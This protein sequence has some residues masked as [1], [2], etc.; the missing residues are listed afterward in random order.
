MRDYSDKTIER[1]RERAM[2]AR[3][4]NIYEA[5]SGMEDYVYGRDGAGRYRIRG[6]SIIVKGCWFIDNQSGEKG[7]AVDFMRY[8]YGYDFKQAVDYLTDED[9]FRDYDNLPKFEKKVEEEYSVSNLDLNL[10]EK[11][12]QDF[13]FPEEDMVK[14]KNNI[15]YYL[16]NE[17][18]IDE[19]ILQ[20]LISKR[21]VRQDKHNNTVFVWYDHKSRI[22]GA[23]K[24]GTYE[25]N[26]NG[27]KMRFR[28]I[29]PNSV[30]G[31]GFNIIKGTPKKVIFFEASIDLISY[32][33][34]N[35]GDKKLNDTLF[36]SMNGLKDVVVHTFL[37]LYPEIE[38]IVFAV[39]NDEA[40]K[41]FI[42]KISESKE[43]QDISHTVEIPNT[44][45]W[46]EDLQY[47]F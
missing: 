20:W 4:A 25:Y 31:M 1:N 5:T 28:G 14:K 32:L 6:T 7:N 19:D 15:I 17:R 18:K 44:K 39:D 35:K 30:N 33:C 36:V 42:R 3:N 47:P 37:K 16:K 41:N 34:L 43:L 21:Y 8:R 26:K 38:E 10:L 23:D 2:Q 22:V 29:V 46:N 27:K 9:D 24:R 11:N 12:I 13:Q 40:G 45:D